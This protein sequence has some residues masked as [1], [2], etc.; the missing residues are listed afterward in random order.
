MKVL[1]CR[2][3]TVE[4]NTDRQRVN[5]SDY[6]KVIED[7]CSGAIAFFERKG[8]IEVKAMLDR[9]E[10]SELHVM[11]I[12]RLGRN[13][14]DILNTIKLFTDKLI[15]VN[16]KSQ[17]IIT[18]ID[19]KEN[20]VA[21]LI[22]SMLGS[23]AEMERNQI[24]ERQKTA[25]MV[26]KAKGVYKGRKHGSVESTEKFLGKPQNKLAMEL[27]SKGYQCKDVAK[28]AEINLNTITKIK[29]LLAPTEQV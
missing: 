10:L 5:E 25:V 21:K 27:L 13:L 15:P 14:L 2:V 28:I 16:I 11:S 1:Y 29:K 18:V 9:G 3:S 19:G 6:E 20:S 17:G 8:G 24:R 22:I 12:D 4:Q 26:A 7:K 23:V